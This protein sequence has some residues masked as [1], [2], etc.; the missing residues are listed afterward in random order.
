MPCILPSMSISI[1]SADGCS[2]SPGIRIMAPAIG[3]TKPAPVDISISLMFKI[4]SLG[5]PLRLG[6]S[7]N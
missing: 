5:L 2:G 3:T 7:D 6:L 4:K 1:F